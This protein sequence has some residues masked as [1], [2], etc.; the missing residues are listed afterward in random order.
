[1]TRNLVRLRPTGKI[2][3]VHGDDERT[4]CRAISAGDCAP[5]GVGT[6]PASNYELCA[7]CRAVERG[8]HVSVIREEDREAIR[9]QPQLAAVL[10]ALSATVDASKIAAKL[11]DEAV[12]MLLADAL[13]PLQDALLLSGWDQ[14][15]LIDQDAADLLGEKADRAG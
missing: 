1:M 6:L 7:T 12:R 4:L 14:G 5:W 15:S 11:G 9:R 13:A 8:C 2:H 10:A 3:I